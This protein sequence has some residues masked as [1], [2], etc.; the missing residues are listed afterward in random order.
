MAMAEV[1]A[2]NAVRIAPTSA[3]SHNLMGMILT[4]AQHPHSGEFHYRRVIELSGA[5]DPILLANL[6]WNLKCQGRIA[7]ARALYQESVEAAP[8]IFQTLFGWGQLE[9]VD[10]NFAAAKAKLDRA[11]EIR[12]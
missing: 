11:A 1:H 5:S 7:E 12:P 9:E 2:R 10:G 8:D 4:E 3:C 6:A